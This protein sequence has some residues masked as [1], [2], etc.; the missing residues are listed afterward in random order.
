M[1][2]ITELTVFAT[3]AGAIAAWAASELT[4]DDTRRFLWTLGAV[5]MLIHSI[6]AYGVFYQ[7]SQQI[8]LTETARRTRA[9]TG[10]D[11]GGGLYLN[12]VFVATWLAHAAWSWRLGEA[13][14]RS[15]VTTFVRGF[16]A[17]M[18][19]NGAVI[20]ANGWMRLLGTIACATVAV[21]W[22]RGRTRVAARI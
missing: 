21:A 15:P 12:Y 7:W 18:F 11:S 19:L 16:A 5:L 3:I 6:A 22:L 14:Q 2:L 10:V 8:A 17:F 20:F 4:Q 1:N 13:A 9:F